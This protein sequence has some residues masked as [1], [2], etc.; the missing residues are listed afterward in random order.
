MQDPYRAVRILHFVRQF[1][2]MKKRR[3]AYVAGYQVGLHGHGLNAIGMK[4]IWVR[5]GLSGRYYTPRTEEERADF[6][7]NNLTEVWEELMG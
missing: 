4:T 1:D 5:Q 7:A 6:V 3:E 2:I